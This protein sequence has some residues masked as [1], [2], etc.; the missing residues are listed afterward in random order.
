M[1]M[2]TTRRA[3][4]AARANR[5]ATMTIAPD[6]SARNGCTGS[7]TGVGSPL[8]HLRTFVSFADERR[9]T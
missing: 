6:G 5:A 4:I 1:L 3:T 8:G 7:L 9:S 2:M